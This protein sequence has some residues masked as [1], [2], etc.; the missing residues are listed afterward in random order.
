MLSMIS[1]MICAFEVLFL[2]LW[3]DTVCHKMQFLTWNL[4]KSVLC[5]LLQSF[6]C[7]LSVYI[8]LQVC[9]AQSRVS[10]PLMPI[11]V[12]QGYGQW[13]SIVPLPT[14]CRAF[15]VGNLPHSCLQSVLSLVD[16]TV[17][18]GILYLR[19][20]KRNKLT[21]SRCCT[22]TALLCPCIS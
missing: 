8:Y 4:S 12:S 7:V 5:F 20:Y 13:S 21:V 14:V 1:N 22:A 15:T 19:T 9:K 10:V 11:I 3:L 17:L 2:H 18:V 6:Y 16:G